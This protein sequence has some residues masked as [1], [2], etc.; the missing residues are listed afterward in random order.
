VRGWVCLCAGCVCVFCPAC[1]CVICLWRRAH[2][3][4]VL[5]GPCAPCA[6]NQWALDFEGNLASARPITRS[7]LLHLL[8]PP[9]PPPPS[10]FLCGSFYFILPHFFGASLAIALTPKL[11]ASPGMHRRGS[12][13]RLRKRRARG[14]GTA[15]APSWSSRATAARTTFWSWTPWNTLG[16]CPLLGGSG[17][18]HPRQSSVCSQDPAYHAGLRLLLGPGG[19]WSPRHRVPFMLADEGSKCVG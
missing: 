5:C 6:L 16:R 18:H 13:L 10:P 3:G 1:V 19:C 17:A 11:E 12:R 2:G 4:R 9:L 15:W 14:R 8:P 7:L